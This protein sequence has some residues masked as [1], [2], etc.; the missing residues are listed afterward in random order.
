MPISRYYD[1]R[2]TPGGGR[3][4]VTGL[5]GMA[6]LGLP[7]LNKGT[8]FTAPERRT[9]G[10]D[11]LL[12]PR[13]TT[14][15]EQVAQV[16]ARYQTLRTD[17]DRHVFLRGLQDENEVLFHAVVQGNIAATMPIL[18]TPTV[19]EAVRRFSDIY[20]TPRGLTVTAQDAG[21]VGDL[22]DN[23]DLAD[24]RLAVV[25]D[26]AAILGIGDQGVGGIGISIGKLTLYTA[27]GGL[28]PDRTLPV[29]LDV[30]TDRADLRDDPA[31]L[32]VAGSRLTGDAYLAVVDAF[33]DAFRRRYPYAV[34]QWEDLSKDTAFAVLRRHRAT[35]PSFNDD[36]QGTGAVTLAGVLSACRRKGEK[37]ADQRIVIH[38]AGAGGIGVAQVLV[39]GMVRQ[40]LDPDDARNHVFVLDSRGLLTAGRDMEDYKRPFAKGPEIV[41]GWGIDGGAPDLLETIVR[42]RATVLIGLSGQCGAFDERIVRSMLE[43][44]RQPI[45]LPLSNPTASCEAVPAD[46]L[47]WTGGNALLATGSPFDDVTFDGVTHPIGQGNNAFV[48]PGLGLGAVLAK[49]SAVSDDM[50]LEAAYALHD[51]TVDLHPDRVYP[52]VDELR[53]V[54]ALVAA[55]V[56]RQAVREG[57]ARDAAVVA[58]DDD[59]LRRHVE[60]HAWVAHYLPVVPDLPVIPDLP[61]V[62][63][64]APGMIDVRDPSAVAAG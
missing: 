50:V 33:V 64:E 51:Y 15:A 10:L 43:H 54:S 42:S 60:D 20:R 56:A 34:L 46:V 55:R 44:A 40:G 8:A 63:A 11:G 23:L 57:L 31:Y 62:P 7:A 45:V 59:A 30:G 53:A 28:E 9:L 48:F 6:V 36:V 2:Q 1:I 4:L 24:V 18:Y 21:R 38:G 17:L 29:A 35:L 25:T 22:L 3:E 27:G 32:G 19:G 37:L 47:R 5:R 58:M 12:P 39:A 49:A 26:S 13:V 14:L 41:D 52:P 61:V 16:W